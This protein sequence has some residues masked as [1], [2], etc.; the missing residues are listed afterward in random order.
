MFKNMLKK[1]L[2]EIVLNNQTRVFVDS[3]LTPQLHDRQAATYDEAVD[4]TSTIGLHHNNNFSEKNRL[5][6]KNDGRLYTIEFARLKD[7]RFIK[8]HS[9]MDSTYLS[10]LR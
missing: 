8:R 9:D 7:K 3:S 10:K 4:V 6:I 1:P 2:T 5:A